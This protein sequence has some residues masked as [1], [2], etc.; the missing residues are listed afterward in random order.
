MLRQKNGLIAGPP[1]IFGALV[2][3]KRSSQNYSSNCKK[4]IIPSYYLG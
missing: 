4:D 3:E 1:A 2:V